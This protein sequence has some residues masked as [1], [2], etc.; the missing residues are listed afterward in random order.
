[1]ARRFT[2]GSSERIVV[3]A[4]SDLAGLN[5]TFGT[6]AAVMY[7]SADTG[8]F[9]TIL[10]FNNAFQFL[11]DNADILTLFVSP[12]NRTMAGTIS[13]GTWYL[14]VVTKA[15]GTAT[16][17]GHRYVFN[18]NTWTHANFSG[19]HP[20]AGTTTRLDFGSFNSAGSEF[21]SSE[22]LAY[23]I[24]PTQV[25]TDSECERLA[26]GNWPSL[27][28]AFYAQ[29]GDGREVGDMAATLGRHRI[30]QTSRTGTTRGVQRPPAGFRMSI[31]GRRR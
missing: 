20:N 30:K 2:S 4:A 21:L 9:E 17:R 3:S 28:P 6:F 8:T 29:F 31:T 13:T 14:F 12:N 16:P 27:S 19:T 5:W 15:T 18:T 22:V 23:G 11:I 25:M 1:M 24:W 7:R 26:R 10:T